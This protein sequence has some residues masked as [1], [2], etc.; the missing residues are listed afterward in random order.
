MRSVHV[1]QAISTVVVVP[2]INISRRL[3]EV[4]HSIDLRHFVNFTC[5]HETTS[6]IFNTIDSVFMA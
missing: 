1:Y 3:S 5:V 2:S 6:K 4:V